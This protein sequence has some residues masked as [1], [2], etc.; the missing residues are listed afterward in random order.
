MSASL[1]LLVV[2]FKDEESI[3]LVVLSPILIAVL[4][5]DK[6]CDFLR[7]LLLVQGLSRSR[8]LKFI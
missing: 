7:G 6:E 5:E 4:V 1:V 2:P 8:V 3:F